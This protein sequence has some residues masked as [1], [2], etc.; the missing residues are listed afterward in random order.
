MGVP[1]DRD[2]IQSA[3]RNRKVA[4]ARDFLFKHFAYLRGYPRSE[5]DTQP[6]YASTGVIFA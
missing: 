4:G 5:T 1:H 2:A 6:V 3:G